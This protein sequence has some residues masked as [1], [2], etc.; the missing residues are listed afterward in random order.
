M[1]AA[2][3]WGADPPDA[4]ALK[5]AGWRDEDITWEHIQIA[6]GQAL[7]AGKAKEA[8]DFWRIGLE[9]AREA[10]AADDLRL[11]TSLA[12]HAA[13]HRLTGGKA[14]AA[15]LFAEALAIWRAR[16]TWIDG[17]AP[18][19]RA[20]SSL[21]HLRLERGYP[22]AYDEKARARY[23]A[24]AEEGLEALEAL[25]AEQGKSRGGLAR[26]DKLRP[27]GYDDARKLLAA[28]LLL[29]N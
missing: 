18:D 5:R 4:A 15:P 2:P 22:G 19:R 17:L 10:F 12:N 21:Y 29:A 28:V 8:A 3:T 27:D 6:A 14:E 25:A 9:V 7:A 24:L 11:A 23:R 16:A 26:W 13:G 20:R 1:C